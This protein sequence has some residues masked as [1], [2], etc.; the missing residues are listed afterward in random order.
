MEKERLEKEFNNL[1]STIRDVEDTSGGNSAD[2][3]IEH[4]KLIAKQKLDLEGVNNNEYN[5][6]HFILE[7]G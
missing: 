5:S 1:K 6:I 3:Y 2:E 7:I 4:I